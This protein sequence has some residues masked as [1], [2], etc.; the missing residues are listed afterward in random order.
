[1][2][3]GARLGHSWRDGKLLFP[4]LASDFASMTRAALALFEASGE[5]AYLDRALAW[6]GAL[7]QYYANAQ[8]GGYYLTAADAEGLVVRPQSTLD[9][10]IPNA[11]AL[12]AKNLVRLTLLTGEDRWRERADRLFDGLLPLAAE[13]VFSHVALLNALDLRMSAAE[14]VVIG[15]DPEPLAAAA[16]AL[17]YLN[18]IVLRAKTAADLPP[19]H[20]AR[21]AFTHLAGTAALVCVGEKCSRP[22]TEP[23]ELA[24]A[25]RAAR[26]PSPA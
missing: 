3:R 24:E 9:E 17:P 11:N 20:P 25:V 23:A 14:I 6:Q 5:Q 21:A 4:G 18:R 19:S 8:T 10:A 13:N 16:R 22:V 7:E 15:P 1:M 2:T 12:I 26:E